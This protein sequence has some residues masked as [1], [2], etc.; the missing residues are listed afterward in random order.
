MSGDEV[1]IAA[2][3]DLIGE[4]DYVQGRNLHRR[5]ADKV[6]IDRFE[7]AMSL[8]RLARQGVVTGVTDRGEASGRVSL[9]IVRPEKSE[10]ISQVRWREALL[11]AGLT[12]SDAKSLITCHDRLDGFSDADMGGLARGLFALRA[13]QESD[14][15]MPRFVLSAKYLLGS[16]KIFGNLSASALRSFGIDVDSF[17]D[18]IPQVVV[19]GPASPEAVLLIENPHSFEE[20]VAAGCA[21]NI[22][23][24]V[25]YGYGL[26]RAGEA[27]GNALAEAV[28]QA[29]RLVPLVRRGNPPAP[30]ILL[31]HPRIFF[32]GDLDKEGLRIYSRL[33]KR[34]PMLRASAL[35]WPMIKAMKQGRSHPYTRAT[36]KERQFDAEI[37]PNDI[38]SLVP[39]CLARGVDQEIVERTDIADMSKYSFLEIE[40]EAMAVSFDRS[41]FSAGKEVLSNQLDECGLLP[42]ISIID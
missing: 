24:I 4:R 31:R 16:S 8:G 34:I 33:Q 32:W 23:L 10:P 37:V 9:T 11:T 12:E 42:K 1:I 36:A 7:A 18:A 28:E 35:Y 40:S 27:Y 39:I 14:R 29:D 30:K 25:T 13:N 20:A 3:Q 21:E 15:G 2:L 22:A 5:I 17:P 38:E 6:G 41:S 19:A 26:S